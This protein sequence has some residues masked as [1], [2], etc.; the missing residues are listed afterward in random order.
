MAFVILLTSK[1]CVGDITP[2]VSVI[3]PEVSVITPEVS[4]IADENL[5]TIPTVVKS[6]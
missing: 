4:A 3:T 6:E 1:M 2:E 5:T